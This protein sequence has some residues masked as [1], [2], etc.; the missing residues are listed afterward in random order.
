MGEARR[1]QVLTRMRW[2]DSELKDRDFIGVDHYNVADVTAQVAL[3]TARG[4]P[5][6]PIPEDHTNLAA[7]WARVSA[8][9]QRAGLK[10]FPSF[11]P[12]ASC[13]LMTRETRA[14]QENMSGPQE[15]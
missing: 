1:E 4:A 13:A 2:L 12:R 11:G 6:L 14:V 15:S 8:P 9:P 5:K 10:A 3:L 7:W